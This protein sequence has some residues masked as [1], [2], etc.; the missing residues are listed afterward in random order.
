MAN[1]DL[2]VMSGFL[3]PISSPETSARNY[4]FSLR[5]KPQELSSHLLR[6]GS[7]L[8]SEDGTDRLSRNIGKILPLNLI[9][10]EPCIV[11]WLS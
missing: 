4:H 8:I 11:V 5:N 1:Y 6:G 10:M 3:E 2:C 7:L 9:F